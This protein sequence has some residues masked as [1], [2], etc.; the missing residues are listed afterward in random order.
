[1]VSMNYLR[2]G[3]VIDAESTS[4]GPHPESAAI[5]SYLD[6][7]LPAAEKARLQAHLAECS[8]CRDEVVE[9][10]ELMEAQKTGRRRR[11]IVPVVAAAAVAATVLLVSMPVVREESDRTSIVRAPEAAAER[12]ALR[13]IS[14]LSPLQERPVERD[15]LAFAWQP[16]AEDASY[17][18]TVT[19]SAGV[20]MWVAETDQSRIVAPPDV[21]LESGTRYL[22]FVDAV[23]PDGTTATTGVQPF[24]IAP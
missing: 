21:D 8:D 9:L 7:R 5:A 18:L 19:D 14:P 12:E 6:D 1:M 11:W 2:G 4:P 15:A 23:L 13:A 24:Q 20:P 10:V 22:W 3:A 17:R 16:I